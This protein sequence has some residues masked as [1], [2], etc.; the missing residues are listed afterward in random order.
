MSQES[1]QG[2]EGMVCLYSIEPEVWNHWNVIHSHIWQLALAVGSPCGPHPMVC[3]HG[4][5]GSPQHGPWDLRARVPKEGDEWKLNPFMTQPSRSHSITSVTLHCMMPSEVL[6]KIRGRGGGGIN[7]PLHGG[8][9]ITLWEVHVE[10][11]FV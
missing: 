10:W 3:V 11:D 4:C 1:G 6:T 2:T 5:L 7:P 8:V 9:S